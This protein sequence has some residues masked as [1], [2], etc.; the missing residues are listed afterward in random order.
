MNELEVRVARDPMD[1]YEEDVRFYLR[2]RNA[3]TQT[4][5]I[6]RPLVLDSVPI[7]EA[8][9]RI[10]DPTFRLESHQAQRLMDG[11]WECGLRPSEGTGSAG[12]LA[13]TERHLSDMQRIVF[14][15]YS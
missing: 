10:V 12:S 1:P 15:D 14:K 5:G 8:K 6:V 9:G 13:A 7:S 3:E 11:L 2:E 4:L